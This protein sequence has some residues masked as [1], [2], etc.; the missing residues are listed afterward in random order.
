MTKIKPRSDKNTKGEQLYRCPFPNCGAIFAKEE[1]KPD[2]CIKH[3]VLINDVL[4]IL[5][6]T[7]PPETVPA[8]ET[9]PKI[10]VPKPG[11]S[12]QAIKEAINNPKGGNKQ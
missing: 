2:T 5:D 7:R 9:G 4:F 11:M 12:I 1:G 6:R 10:Y 8:E 3:R